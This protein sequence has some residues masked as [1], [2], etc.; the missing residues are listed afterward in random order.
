MIDD[1]IGAQFAG[2]LHL[3]LVAGGGDH[4]RVEQFGDLDGGDADAGIRAQNQHGLS[5]TDRG[6]SDQHVPRGNETPAARSPPR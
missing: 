3:A 2:A 5:G 6:A 4:A 1:V